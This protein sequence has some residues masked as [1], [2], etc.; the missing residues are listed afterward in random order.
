MTNQILTCNLIN[1]SHWTCLSLAASAN[2]KDFLS[3]TACQFLISELWI[4]GMKLKKH[5]TFKVITA[6]I[7]PPAIF[8]IEFK[9]AK[10]LKFMPQTEEEYEQEL[11]NQLPSSSNSNPFYSF[12][13]K[14][15][16]KTVT[17]VKSNVYIIKNEIKNYKNYK[18]SSPEWFELYNIKQSENCHQNLNFENNEDQERSI[19]NSIINEENLF[20]KEKKKDKLP[21][22]KKIYEFY[23]AP[24]TKFWQNVLLYIVFLMCFSYFVLQKTPNS[25]SKSEIF[26]LVYIFS[27]GLDKIIEV[28]KQFYLLINY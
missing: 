10:E 1:W 21:I 24:I 15:K 25:F 5:V 27:Y 8:T 11:E 4:G 19:R 13:S 26:V 7:F 20:L 2:L 9:S 12:G 17:P 23:H 16:K 18:N 6:L 3:H 28:F 14:F 22:G